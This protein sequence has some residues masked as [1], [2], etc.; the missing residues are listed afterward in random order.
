M[1]LKALP[2]LSPKGKRV[3]QRIMHIATRTIHQRTN[4]DKMLTKDVHKVWDRCMQRDVADAVDRILRE[5]QI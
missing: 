5:E 3:K 1:K 2:P 4:D